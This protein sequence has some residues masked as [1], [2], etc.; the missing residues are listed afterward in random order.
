MPRSSSQPVNSSTGTVSPTVTTRDICARA[1]GRGTG[2]NIAWNG[3]TIRRGGFGPLK[4]LEHAEPAAEDL[5][6][7]VQLARELV[8]GGEDLRSD[9]GE[10]R[11]VVAKI[12]HVADMSQHD[13]Q[14]RRGMQPQGRRTTRAAAEP[15]APSM[16][17]LR[18]FFNDAR[19][20]GNPCAR[21]INLVRSLS[22]PT[23]ELGADFV[24]L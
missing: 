9:P 20:S 6:G 19:S 7:G 14:R 2:W 22:P 5:V 15:Q 11:H 8:P 10:G 1:S 16:V 18:L 21:W 12:V 17:A 13:H 4:L 24:E 23:C 3:A